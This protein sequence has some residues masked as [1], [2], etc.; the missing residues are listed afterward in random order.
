MR[1][2][3][4]EIGQIN[5]REVLGVS[6]NARFHH[7]AGIRGEGIITRDG[8]KIPGRISHIVAI[9]GE[10]PKGEEEAKRFAKGRHYSG[11]PVEVVYITE[12]D[13]YMRRDPMLNMQDPQDSGVFRPYIHGSN[14]GAHRSAYQKFEPPKPRR[15]KV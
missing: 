13:H 11:K 12:G 10:D 2:L 14:D 3:E 6:P 1:H 7:A 15:R 9:F 4:R 5:L 8:G